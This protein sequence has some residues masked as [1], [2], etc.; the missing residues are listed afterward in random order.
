MTLPSPTC[1]LLGIIVCLLANNQIRGVLSRPTTSDVSVNVAMN[2]E[3]E[4]EVGGMESIVNLSIDGGAVSN[5]DG[6][7][8]DQMEPLSAPCNCE[9]CDSFCDCENCTNETSDIEGKAPPLQGKI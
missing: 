2:I 6:A 4:N 8:I 7:G 1:L 3:G 9:D 5:E